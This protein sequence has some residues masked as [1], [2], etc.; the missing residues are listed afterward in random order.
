MRDVHPQNPQIQ[1]RRYR[2]TFQTCMHRTLL[3]ANHQQMDGQHH[4]HLVPKREQIQ[5]LSQSRVCVGPAWFRAC[6]DFGRGRCQNRL[7]HVRCN[8]HLRR[9]VCSIVLC[10]VQVKRSYSRLDLLSISSDYRVHC[11]QH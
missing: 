7:G 10:I 2:C 11:H 6:L 5:L 8:L 4:Q 3:S 1:S 9:H